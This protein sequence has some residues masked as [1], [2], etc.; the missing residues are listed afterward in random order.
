L[1]LF[2]ALAIFAAGMC[3][4]TINSVVGSGTL[5]T[6]WTRARVRRFGAASTLGAIIGATLL[7]TLPASAFDAI[8]PVC[9]VLALILIVFQG[10]LT[11]VVERRGRVNVTRPG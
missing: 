11:K 5:I 9:T 8:V 10:R 2:D 1:G 4:G 7:L 6:E 3:A